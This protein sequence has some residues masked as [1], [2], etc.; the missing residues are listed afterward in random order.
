MVNITSHHEMLVLWKKGDLG[1]FATSSSLVFTWSLHFL[2]CF[3]YYVDLSHDGTIVTCVQAGHTLLNCYVESLLSWWTGLKLIWLP[4]T[5]EW[6]VSSEAS[7]PENSSLLLP[8][9]IWATYLQWQLV[10]YTGIHT[11]L[12]AA[13]YDSNLRLTITPATV[14][15]LLLFGVIPPHC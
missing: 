15:G 10:T 9:L 13:L 1:G 2:P 6:Q 8:P 14:S 4:L 5:S 7:P 12:W 11:D 3:L